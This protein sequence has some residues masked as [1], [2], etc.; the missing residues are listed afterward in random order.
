MVR[1]FVV[2]FA[3]R[4]WQESHRVSFLTT[5]QCYRLEAEGCGEYPD[6]CT[7]EGD[8]SDTSQVDVEQAF[9]LPNPNI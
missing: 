1:L 8:S 6:K 3:C 9:L 2:V 4:I 7:H 5:L